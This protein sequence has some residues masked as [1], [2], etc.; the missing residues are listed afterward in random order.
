MPGVSSHTIMQLAIVDVDAVIRLDRGPR[1]SR[2]RKGGGRAAT[3]CRS[4]RAGRTVETV[5]LVHIILVG[6]VAVKL[7]D[8]EVK[9]CCASWIIVVVI[10]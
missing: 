4:S 2:R 5:G 7:G 3:V 1:R 6:I 10:G 8:I 9:M